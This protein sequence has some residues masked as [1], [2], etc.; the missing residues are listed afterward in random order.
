ME[1]KLN[2]PEQCPP[3]NAISVNLAPVYRLVDGE[4]VSSS[5]LLSHVEAG[6][7]FPPGQECQ[8]H[9]ISLFQDIEDVK[10]NKRSLKS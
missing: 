1:F 6:L 7:S 9:A 4:E 10:D 5:D 2:L 3:G 8:A